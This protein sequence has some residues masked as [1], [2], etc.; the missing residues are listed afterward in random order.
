MNILFIANNSPFSN[1]KHGGAETSLRLLAEKLADAGYNIFFLS[2]NHDRTVQTSITLLR[3]PE[4]LQKIPFN[5]LPFGKNIQKALRRKF[6]K[7]TIQKNDIKIVQ[8]FYAL[9]NLQALADLKKAGLKF[10]IIMRMAGL[11]W[12]E[13]CLENPRLKKAYQ[14]AFQYVD[15]VNYIHPDLKQ[16]VEAKIKELG[17]SVAF[18]HA[19][20]GDI[21]VSSPIGRQNQYKIG[22][23]GPFKLLMVAR[24]SAYQKRYDLLLEAIALLKNKISLQ[25]SLIGDGDLKEEMKQL[26]SNLGLNDIVTFLPF[27]ERGELWEY[28]KKNHLLCHA[29][30]YEGLGKV[31]LESMALGLPILASNVSPLNEYIHDGDNGFLANNTP[32]AW[33]SKIES[34]YN[35]TTLLG[36]ISKREIIFIEKN[37]N[38]IANINLYVRE[39]ERLART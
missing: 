4:Y 14:D 38:P 20:S 35:S 10:K 31:I 29:C 2:Y 1:E 18:K 23:E 37:Y 34:L 13:Q 27:M 21:G 11:H 7:E 8:C 9:D 33:A 12:Y 32:V 5:R 26:S 19:F 17:M 30:E 22:A 28:M 25:V 24:F 39:I 6:L 3:L 16:M 36:D 15:S